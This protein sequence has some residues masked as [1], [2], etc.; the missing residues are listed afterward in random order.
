MVVSSGCGFGVGAF[1][2]KDRSGTFRTEDQSGVKEGYERVRGES[3]TDVGEQFG[4][5]IGFKPQLVFGPPP[6]SGDFGVGYGFDAHLNL[7]W[8][9]LELTGGY[10]SE[11]L[12]F[13]DQSRFHSGAGVVGLNYYFPI[14]PGFLY[15]YLGAAFQMGEVTLTP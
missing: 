3:W 5:S 9:M 7:R 11:A 13:D 1:R 6:K 15:A 2:G 12:N 10:V 14:E 8:R 4:V